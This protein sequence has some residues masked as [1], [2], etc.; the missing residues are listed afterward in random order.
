V[1]VVVKDGDVEV[2][3]DPLLDLDAARIN[4]QSEAS[5][6]MRLY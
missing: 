3:L 2:T 1:L 4:G 5:P 6:R